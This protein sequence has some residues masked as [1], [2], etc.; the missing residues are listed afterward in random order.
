MIAASSSSW[1]RWGLRPARRRAALRGPCSPSRVRLRTFFIRCGMEQRRSGECCLDADP[2]RHGRAKTGCSGGRARHPGGAE[3]LRRA[4]GDDVQRHGRD[5]G[6]LRVSPA[7]ALAHGEAGGRRVGPPGR[8]LR[9]RPDH[10][11][12]HGGGC[13]PP[14]CR[15]AAGVGRVRA[16]R[17]GLR[18]LLAA[19]VSVRAVSP[20]LRDGRPSSEQ[21][22]SCS[23]GLV[24]RR[25][26]A[27]ACARALLPA[28]R[29]PD[30]G[31]GLC[32]LLRGH[33]GRHP[34]V[35]PVRAAAGFSSTHQQ[36]RSRS[37][38]LCGVACRVGL[39]E[40]S[41]RRAE[42]P[43]EAGAGRGGGDSACRSLDVGS[44]G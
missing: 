35:R 12:R 13:D 26:H 5:A 8:R 6:V 18:R 1:P 25:R 39:D 43:R 17:G 7:S 21:E 29:R 37:P 40:L 24:R 19:Q 38:A 27:D 42:L 9:A 20:R 28:R 16:A 33:G 22:P 31:R 2:G 14:H 4:R 41:E 10:G 15:V 32:R 3:L 23:S 34:P 44:A 36:P 30:R 11:H